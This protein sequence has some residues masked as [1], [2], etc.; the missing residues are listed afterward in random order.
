MI[1]TKKYITDLG[2]IAPKKT[3]QYLDEIGK[4]EV[5]DLPNVEQYE[6]AR[7]DLEFTDRFKSSKFRKTQTT[8]KRVGNWPYYCPENS[9]TVPSQVEIPSYTKNQPSS[10]GAS[11]PPVNTYKVRINKTIKNEYIP[12]AN[13]V[14]GYSKGI[15]ML[16]AIMTNQEGFAAYTGPNASR[17]NNKKYGGSYRGTYYN[18]VT[19]KVGT[20]GYRT[21][22]PGNV[23]NTDNGATV[24]YPTLEAGISKQL[25]HLEEI[26]R[27]IGRT[28]KA[29][30][31][32]QKKIILPF[33]S[34]EVD[35]NYSNYGLT[36]YFPGYKFLY[37]GK[38]S[39]FIKIYSTGARGGNNYLTL[40]LSFFKLNGIDATP[41]TTL[42]EILTLDD[43]KPIIYK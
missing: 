14:K 3:N 1:N 27:G 8:T 10:K 16:A 17:R 31:L 41:N 39:Q 23:G 29:Y 9:S 35:N 2:F 33:Y 15:K 7:G 40:I 32:N 25:G 4:W 6:E 37:I 19:G 42:G 26:A 18:S 12:A 34:E 24:E 21:N 13:N 38:L 5:L 36:P 28:A 11:N 30:P 22:N 43:P 20:K